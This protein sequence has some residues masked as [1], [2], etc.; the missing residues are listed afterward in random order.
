[1]V[2]TERK[3]QAAGQGDG[4]KDAPGLAEISMRSIA[5]AHVTQTA[6]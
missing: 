5:A 1:M 4:L 2:F 6:H 3:L